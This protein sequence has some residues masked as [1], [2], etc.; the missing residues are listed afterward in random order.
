MEGREAAVRGCI[1]FCTVA[2]NPCGKYSKM[3]Q[4]HRFTINQLVVDAS[5]CGLQEGI[6]LVCGNR[7]D[8]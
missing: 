2:G 8:M 7:A 3:T 1:H 4:L 6:C 5:V